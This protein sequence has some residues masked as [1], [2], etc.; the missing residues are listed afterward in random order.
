[1][2]AVHLRR[3]PGRVLVSCERLG[4]SA[5]TPQQGQRLCKPTTLKERPKCP[6]PLSTPK[7]AREGGN[8]NIPQPDMWGLGLLIAAVLVDDVCRGTSVT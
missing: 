1:M 4:R 8:A 5:R 6:G 2:E 3:A 7:A